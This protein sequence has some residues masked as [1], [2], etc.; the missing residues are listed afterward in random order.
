MKGLGNRLAILGL[1]GLPFLCGCLWIPV[2]VIAVVAAVDTGKG[3][4]GAVP[5]L[6][7]AIPP[8]PAP[9]QGAFY[10]LPGDAVDV[11]AGN[12]VPDPPGSPGSQESHLDIAVITEVTH[13]TSVNLFEGDGAGRFPERFT[14]PLTGDRA[15]ALAVLP[16]N[17]GGLDLLLAAT[18]STLELIRPLVE[19]GNF[20]NL[21]IDADLVFEPDHRSMAIA[22]FDGNGTKDVAVASKSSSRIDFFFGEQAENGQ[23]LFKKSVSSLSAGFPRDLAAANFDGDPNN[24]SDLVVLVEESQATT[25]N[26]YLSSQTG[27]SA[28]LRLESSLAIAE[29]GNSIA[30]HD[31]AWFNDDLYPDILVALASDEATRVLIIP[32]PGG[33]GGKFGLSR[34]PRSGSLTGPPADMELIHLPGGPVR[35]G[36]GTKVI[37]HATVDR[38][39]RA[40]TCVYSSDD[41]LGT[42][43]PIAYFL[44]GEGRALRSGDF[45][46]DGFADLAAVTAETATLTVLLAK[47]PSMVPKTDPFYKVEDD[48]LNYFSGTTAGED[49]L[50]TPG[51]LGIAFGIAGVNRDKPFLATVSRVSD[52]V[53]VFYLNLDNLSVTSIERYRQV[54]KGARSIAVANFDG[55]NGDDIVVTATKEGKVFLLPDSGTDNLRFKEKKILLDLSAIH[56]NPRIPQD[57]LGL[58]FGVETGFRV[59][60]AAYLDGNTYPDLIV[61]ITTQKFDEDFVAVLLNPGD[62]QTSDLQFFRTLDDPRGVA[63]ANLNGDLAPD[64]LVACEGTSPDFGNSVHVLFGDPQNPGRFFEDQKW[65]LKNDPD[66]ILPPG[67]LDPL[68]LRGAETIDGEVEVVATDNNPL[69]AGESFKPFGQWPVA[70]WIVASNSRNFSMYFNRIAENCIPS[71]LDSCFEGPFLVLSESEGRSDPED[72]LVFDLFDDADLAPDLAILDEGSGE[73]VFLKNAG[74][75][76]CDNNVKPKEIWCPSGTFKVGSPQ[77]SALFRTSDGVLNLAVL[78][79]SQGEI[80]VFK[81]VS[82]GGRT[83][84]SPA[85]NGKIPL[86]EP[87]RIGKSTGFAV[88]GEM[89]DRILVASLV[90]D[91]DRESG[92]PAIDC[93]SIPKNLTKREIAAIGSPGSDIARSRI[94]FENSLYEPSTL[95][96]G[97]LQEPMDIPELLIFEQLGALASYSWEQMSNAWLDRQELLKTSFQSSLVSF[98]RVSRD[99]NRELL[100]AATDHEVRILEIQAAIQASPLSARILWSSSSSIGV[101]QAAPLRFQ[102]PGGLSDE[103]YVVS[104]LGPKTSSDPTV[105]IERAGQPRDRLEI[106]TDPFQSGRMGTRDLNGDRID[107]LVIVDGDRSILRVFFASKSA[108]GLQLSPRQSLAYDD[109]GEPVDLD[110]GDF[111]GDSKIDVCLGQ[112][113]KVRDGYVLL[114]SGNGRGDFSEPSKSFAGPDLEAVRSADLDGDGIDEILASVRVPGLVILT[115]N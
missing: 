89:E 87:D 58:K 34:H 27:G 83:I 2:A 104:L 23:L 40:L 81:Q 46:N 19:P 67:Y 49:P 51:G 64:L 71:P 100:L 28:Q 41:G 103:L 38:G 113:E 95:E 14:I 7:P 107:D 78:S 52:E 76:N 79:R 17:E 80:I 36:A 1:L 59:I 47:T 108:A 10:Q 5:P 50:R 75:G 96:L 31:Q 77:G 70:R 29:A 82:L 18:S 56:P 54:G 73:L 32:P 106:F 74:S 92:H 57:L 22:D 62:P 39:S 94:L 24:Q 6:P 15:L 11:A 12:F 55:E 110:F 4:S 8:A 43:D 69:V 98:K 90:E 44:P 65:L 85:K 66:S 97:R 99:S 111:N 114:F 60:A 30:S 105:V 101:R 88:M 48:P 102:G 93:L 35:E 45:N 3:G 33:S 86:E 9:F 63:V 109:F 26:L 16:G 42:E 91:G 61:P 37:D 20:D 112:R 84:Y 72:I 53:E 25:L 115:G 68:R 13:P 21:V